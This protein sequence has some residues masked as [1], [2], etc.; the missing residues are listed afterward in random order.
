MQR[1][2]SFAR[3]SDMIRFHSLQIEQVNA[4]LEYLE[5]LVI[6][7][8]LQTIWP[9]EPPQVHRTSFAEMIFYTTSGS[10]R[11]NTVQER[12]DYSSDVIRIPSIFLSASN[13][14]NVLG[15]SVSVS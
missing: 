9:G 11:Q 5:S 10:D 12:G 7:N 15:T 6:T 1:Q 2:T 13:S 8:V 3:Y 14:D 4:I